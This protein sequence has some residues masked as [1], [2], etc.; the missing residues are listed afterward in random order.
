MSTNV[1]GVLGEKLGMTQV[2]DDNNKVVPIT[3]V[4]AGP[5]VVTQVRT[6][7]KDGYSAVQIAFG[8]IDP[9]KVNK[10]DAG[11]FTKS[12]VTPRR[13]LVEIRTDDATLSH[14]PDK[15][16]PVRRPP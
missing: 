8:A 1:K 10:P 9:R 11:Q 16:R 3:V 7:D 6:P 4:K 14:V 15:P 5:C 2:W 13:H 12:G